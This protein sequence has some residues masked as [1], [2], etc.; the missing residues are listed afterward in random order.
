[1]DERG[2]VTWIYEDADN[3]SFDTPNCPGCLVRMEPREL[4]SGRYG[5]YCN[6]CAF[7]SI[8]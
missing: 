3:V 2:N 5:W 8:G 1:M 6:V 4:G 7:T